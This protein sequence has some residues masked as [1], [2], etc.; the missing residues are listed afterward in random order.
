V[1]ARRGEEL[2]QRAAA[3]RVGERE[4]LPLVVPVHLEQAL[5]HAVV[6]PRAAEDELLQPVDERLAADERERVPVA[7]RY[8]PSALRGVSIAS[9]STSSTR[10]AVSSS[11]SSGRDEPEPDRRR[12][13]ALL[14][15]EAAEGEAVAEELD[16][17]VVARVVVAGRLHGGSV[18]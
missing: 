7:T 16:D 13:D 15:V 17:V 12:G 14:E 11:S 2:E 3:V 18:P 8:S 1:P 10:S 5:L 4:V 6:E 9:R